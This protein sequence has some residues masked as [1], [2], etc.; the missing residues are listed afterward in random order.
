MTDNIMNIIAKAATFVAA[1]LADPPK[2]ASTT[3]SFSLLAL[4]VR[5]F[6]LLEFP[7]I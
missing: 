1:Q 4:H 7:K 3:R 6:S 5:H 2:P